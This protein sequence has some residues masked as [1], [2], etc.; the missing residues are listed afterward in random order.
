MGDSWLNVV[1]TGPSI[2]QLNSWLHVYKF[3]KCHHHLSALQVENW[4]VETSKIISVTPQ[5]FNVICA[6][7]AVVEV[8]I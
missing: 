7:V 8:Y 1:S 5:T 2:M 4:A 6:R 3:W